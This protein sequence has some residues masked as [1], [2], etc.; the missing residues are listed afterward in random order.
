M[1]THQLL[2]VLA[3]GLAEI[4]AEPTSDLPGPGRMRSLRA[5]RAFRLPD[6]LWH[7][8]RHSDVEKARQADAEFSLGMLARR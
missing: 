3:L 5:H 7:Y 1:V 2:N 4:D 6:G 8:F